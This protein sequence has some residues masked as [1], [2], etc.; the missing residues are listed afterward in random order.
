MISI[1]ANENAMVFAA[2]RQY[3]HQNYYG[4]ESVIAR[5]VAAHEFSACMEGRFVE[6]SGSW[7][8]AKSM[9][10]A[11]NLIVLAG[12]DGTG[13]RTAAL[14]LLAGRCGTSRVIELEATWH[15][16]IEDAMPRIDPGV[17]VLVDLSKL[18]Q[19]G[20]AGEFGPRLKGWARSADVFVVVIAMRNAR[21]ANW[22]TEIRSS[23]VEL[24]S[25]SPRD[26]I[27]KELESA[28]VYV[29]CSELLNHQDIQSILHSDLNA[30]DTCRLGAIVIHSVHADPAEIVDE[31]QDWRTHIEGQLADTTSQFGTRAL[32]WSGAFCHGGSDISVLRMAEELR[33]L[34]DVRRSELDILSE[35]PASRKFSDA[36]IV[37]NGGAAMLR[38]A[39]R[40]YA[41]AVRRHMWS[42]YRQSSDLLTKWLA[43]CI[44]VLPWSD[45][46]RVA[47]NV[48]DIAAQL[49]ANQLMVTVRDALLTSHKNSASS[50][51]SSWAT[52]ERWG[53][54]IR[55]RLYAWSDSP[56]LDTAALVAESCGGGF[57]DSMPVLALTRLRRAAIRCGGG[58]PSVR[59]SLVRMC[60]ADVVLVVDALS[61]WSK[62]DISRTSGLSAAIAI[63]S[64]R[65][66]MVAIEEYCSLGA[67]H[68]A[69]V[70]PP[71]LELLS[72]AMRQQ[73][74]AH[75]AYNVLDNW[76]NFSE[77]GS[78]A[79]DF[80]VAITS[81]LIDVMF[82]ANALEGLIARVWGADDSYWSEV[83]AVTS[84]RAQ[85]GGEAD[86]V[87]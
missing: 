47:N 5:P 4:E 71:I 57:G 70:I 22:A 60:V 54:F 52:D 49:R 83:M 3:F 82:R 48:I 67:G 27:K 20:I 13:R 28:G 36:G 30:R 39:K 65:E 12:E 33:R 85:P 86:V 41:A 15:R 25:P 18:G 56:S 38:P 10:A 40:G 68:T 69:Q 58:H 9:A 32:V 53:G 45:A 37:V 17:G 76:K 87:A 81:Q 21:S 1:D 59:A 78:I 74:L 50:V 46:E 24:G 55:E 16:F 34:V 2:E 11:G 7:A 42:E 29:Q 61:A 79:R 73:D 44:Q 8:S 6:P 31:Y 43:T 75:E 66:G 80:A 23:V 62:M 35:P 19:D 84:E 26:L 51:F 72:A 63:A 77:D 14:R 64:D